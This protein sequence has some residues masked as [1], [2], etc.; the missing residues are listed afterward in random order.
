MQ[1]KKTST[2]GRC[3]ATGRSRPKAASRITI[4]THR[5]FNPER[6]MSRHRVIPLR[7]LSADCKVSLGGDG[8]QVPV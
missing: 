8:R 6:A 3:Q 4:A 2:L 5:L 7:L 1:I